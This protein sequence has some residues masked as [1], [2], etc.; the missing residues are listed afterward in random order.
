M[1]ACVTLAIYPWAHNEMN[2]RGNRDQLTAIPKKNI[3]KVKSQQFLLLNLGFNSCWGLFRFDHNASF[4]HNTIL[5]ILLSSITSDHRCHNPRGRGESCELALLRP[6][7]KP[8]WW[9][10]MEGSC[11][12]YSQVPP[13]RRLWKTMRIMS[14]WCSLKGCR[15][16]LCR[17][18]V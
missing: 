18:W 10:L 14:C 11:E 9:P 13:L 6:A 8:R 1:R 5:S 15:L 3:S 4:K 16:T 17:L 12:L 7:F 2:R